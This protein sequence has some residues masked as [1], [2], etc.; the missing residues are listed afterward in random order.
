MNKQRQ[1]FTIVKVCF[2]I[3]VIIFITAICS[4]FSTRM[5]YSSTD[6]TIQVVAGLIA[7]CLITFLLILFL[8]AVPELK[9]ALLRMFGID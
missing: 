2:F 9:R 6:P 4:D 5:F 3:A 7:I 8:L 1:K